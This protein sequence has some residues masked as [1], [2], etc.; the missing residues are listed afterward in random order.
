MR[1]VLLFGFSGELGGKEL[2]RGHRWDQVIYMVLGKIP[3]AKELT[4][5]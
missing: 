4:S 1:A 2:N 5:S 3:T